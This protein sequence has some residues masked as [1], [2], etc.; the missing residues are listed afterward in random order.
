MKTLSPMIKNLAVSLLPQMDP[1][2][3]MKIWSKLEPFPGGKLIFSEL[4]GKVVPYTGTISPTVMGLS[5]GNSLVVMTDRSDVRNH[6]K[7]IHAMA[8][9]NLGECASGLALLTKLPS[10]HQGILVGFKVEY[11]K[12]ARGTLT[13]RGSVLEWKEI[14]G[15]E[16]QVALALAEIRN[17]QQETVARCFSDWKVSPKD[18]AAHPPASQPSETKKSK[19]KAPL[20]TRI[21]NGSK[22]KKG[23]I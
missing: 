6:L 4:I 3:L 22:P 1:A 18:R 20:K 15:G 21:Q 23:K 19:S 11:L 2:I 13:S 16:E 8:L 17:S 10:T 12:K 14:S 9:A 5:P 7:S